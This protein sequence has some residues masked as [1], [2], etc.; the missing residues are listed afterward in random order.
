MGGG[1]RREG[2]YV[3]LWLIPVDVWQK[4]TQ[5]CKVVILQFKK[6]KMSKKKKRWGE[7]RG[8]GST[9]FVP[10]GRKSRQKAGISVCRNLLQEKEEN[11]AI[12][13]FLNELGVMFS[14]SSPQ[15]FWHQGPV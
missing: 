4:P 14:S 10:N 13:E 12:L 7:I 6:K 9:E 2:T 8:Q 5:Y 1:F 15:S 11:L 3:H